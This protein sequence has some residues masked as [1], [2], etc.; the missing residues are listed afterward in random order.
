MNPLG[1]RP[2]VREIF[3]IVRAG[4]LKQ[5]FFL[6][7]V[8]KKQQVNGLC[9]PKNTVRSTDVFAARCSLNCLTVGS[10]LIGLLGFGVMFPNAAGASQ[11]DW[12]DKTVSYFASEQPLRDVLSNIAGHEGLKMTISPKVDK[13]VSLSLDEKPVREAFQQLVS[14]NDLVSY[15]DGQV[16]FVYTPDEVKTATVKLDTM[17]PS[18]FTEAVEKTGV[19]I[20]EKSWRVSEEDGMVFLS[21]TERFVE[22]IMELAKTL[23]KQPTSFA[24]KWKDSKGQVHYSS[25]PPGDERMGFEVLDFSLSQRVGVS[26]G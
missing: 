1:H 19:S 15:F 25:S 10:A 24:Y 3:E 23:E 7:E 14:M 9:M 22:Q 11:P 2:Y 13:T 17:S 8:M 18:V 21:G 16:M 12:T 26:G 6:G 4:L 5:P 20:D